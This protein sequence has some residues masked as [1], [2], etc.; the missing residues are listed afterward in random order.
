[1]PLAAPPP[2][3]PFRSSA[4]TTK[5]HSAGLAA[6]YARQLQAQA[7]RCQVTLPTCGI[8]TAPVA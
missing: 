7:S 4:P 2:C 5:P 1:M 3:A 6:A 8:F